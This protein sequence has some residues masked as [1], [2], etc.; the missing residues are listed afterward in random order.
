MME[1]DIK[2]LPR[3]DCAVQPESRVRLKQNISR[4]Q[5][6][7]YLKS[8]RYFRFPFFDPTNCYRRDGLFGQLE[9]CLLQVGERLKQRFGQNFV[10][11]NLRG[12]W[13]R[14]IPIRGDD[15]D[16]LFIVKEIS[17]PGKNE[18]RE[19][20]RKELLKTNRLFRM[21]RGKIEQGMKIEP[22]IFFDLSHLR[23]IL[24][25]YMY[26]LGRFL[27]RNRER[28]R[29]TYQ[30][31]FF[32]ST[33]TEKKNQFLK[34]GILIPYVGWVYG[35][36]RKAEV[37]DEIARYLPI[38][39]QPTMLFTVEEIDEAKETL[40]QAF[41]ARNL[42]YPSLEIKKWV[43]LSDFDVDRLKEEAMELY[44]ALQ[45]LDDVYAR[46]IINY[47]Y[48]L[49][50]EERFLGQVVTRE[51][52]CKFAPSY[53]SLVYDIREMAYLRMAKGVSGSD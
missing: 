2:A 4:Q 10:S 51:R 17:E 23:T 31:T 29:D 22:I 8:C 26:G 34:S 42:I 28:R 7:F 15:L 12:S 25:T 50:I 11:I 21:C 49:E 9:E 33:L 13:L 47:I 27:E 52:V 24:N 45:P 30:D 18:I 38:P 6:T 41:I 32:G 46:A 53:D 36:E 39:S 43:R 19:F 1:E 35:R 44:P 3:V 5:I 37:F 48:T 40:R 20:T 16:V 14:G